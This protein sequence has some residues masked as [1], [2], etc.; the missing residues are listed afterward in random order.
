MKVSSVTSGPPLQE[1][2]DNAVPAMI[3]A[4]GARLTAVGFIASFWMIERVQMTIVSIMRHHF[5][6]VGDLG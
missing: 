6:R 1:R 4:N 5:T 3:R 2:A